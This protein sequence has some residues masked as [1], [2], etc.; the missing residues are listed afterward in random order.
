MTLLF[1]FLLFLIG[2]PFGIARIISL[3]VAYAFVPLADRFIFPSPSRFF[4]SRMSHT[5]EHMH[6]F[7]NHE[8]NYYCC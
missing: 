6:A 4:F 2:D 1:H 5:L 8:R 3:L 7:C